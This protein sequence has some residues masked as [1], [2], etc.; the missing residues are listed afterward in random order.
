MTGHLKQVTEVCFVLF[1]EHSLFGVMRSCSV[2]SLLSMFGALWVES[3]REGRA[4]GVG[5]SGC[6]R[7]GWAV[8]HTN[9][10]DLGE[11]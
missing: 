8:P 9:G 3:R 5:G 2:F 4:P 1:W 7:A 6:G 11:Q 10:F